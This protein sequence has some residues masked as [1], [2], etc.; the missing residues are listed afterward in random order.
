MNVVPR[1]LMT[2]I[3]V[4]SADFRGAMRHLTGGVSVITA[5]RGKDITGMTVTSVTSLSVEPPTLLVSINRDA[6]SF[7]LIRRHGAFGVNILNAD[8]LDVA[9]RFA[10]KGG[11]KGADRFKGAKWAT[12]VSG[13]P[14]LVGALSAFDCEVEEIMERHSHGIVI[15]RVRDIKSSMRTAALAYWHGQYVAVDQD[16]DAARLAEVSLPAHGRRGA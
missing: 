7:P 5:G 13:V 2:E 8:Q 15:G 9:E 1:D 12:A 16:E 14:L 10:G 4:S 3:P 11:L 6:S